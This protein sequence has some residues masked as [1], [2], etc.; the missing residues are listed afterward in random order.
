[1]FDLS[2]TPVLRD[3]GLPAESYTFWFA[4]DYPMDGNLNPNGPML[5]DRETVA[6]H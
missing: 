4:I 5:I 2:S 1:M 3:T 6:V